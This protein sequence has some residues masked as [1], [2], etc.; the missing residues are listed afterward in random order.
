MIWSMWPVKSWL[1]P[2]CEHPFNN[3]NSLKYMTPTQIR[4]AQTIGLAVMETIQESG[5]LGAP[6]GVLFAAMQAQGCTL[7]QFESLM[8]PMLRKGFVELDALCYTITEAG[9]TFIADLRR[10]LGLP[11]AVAASRAPAST[12]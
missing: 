4:T 12:F 10:T 8:G 9:T 2:S 3:V 5:T 7:Q 1:Y 6:S 11:P